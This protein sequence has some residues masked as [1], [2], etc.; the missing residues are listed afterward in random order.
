MAAAEP[1]WNLVQAALVAQLKNIRRSTNSDTYWYDVREVSEIPQGAGKIDT[2]RLPALIVLPEPNLSN[3]AHVGGNSK[4]VEAVAAFTITA[5]MRNDAGDRVD[6]FRE[7]GRMVRDIH[8]AISATPNLGLSRVRPLRFPQGP[9]YDPAE[10][11]GTISLIRF[12]YVVLV[13]YS[14]EW[15]SP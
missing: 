14:F 3:Q 1:Q 11:T 7:M 5:I 6:P 9:Q 4:T 15:D 2:S 10:L 13:P 12:D 8:M